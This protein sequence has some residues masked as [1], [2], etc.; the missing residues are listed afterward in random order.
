MGREARFRGE[1]LSFCIIIADP[2]ILGLTL[3][4]SPPKQMFL[5]VGAQTSGAIG[6]LEDFESLTRLCVLLMFL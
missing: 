1:M 4:F 2:F 3:S 6:I 5:R